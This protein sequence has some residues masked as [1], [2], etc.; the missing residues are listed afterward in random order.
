[1]QACRPWLT[2]CH[3][4]HFNDPLYELYYTRCWYGRERPE[5]EADNCHG[6]K[7]FQPAAIF[8]D[9]VN[10]LDKIRDPIS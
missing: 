5:L 8:D 4:W 10:R 1:M 9:L 7:K 2:Y 6:S 3:Y